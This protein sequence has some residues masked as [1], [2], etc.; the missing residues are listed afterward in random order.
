MN[1]RLTAGILLIVGGICT[2]AYFEYSFRP[3]EVDVPVALS[4]GHTT[5]EFIAQYD[6]RYRIGVGFGEPEK[7][8]Y[9]KSDCITD[10]GF[11]PG[12]CSSIPF[13]VKAAWRLSSG[14]QTIKQ[15]L[16]PS[17]MS[18]G[19]GPFFASFGVFQAEGARRYKLE[20]E[21]LTDGS[22]LAPARPRLQV[23]VREPEFGKTIGPG[24]RVLK[25]K[26]IVRA[27]YA[28]SILIGVVMILSWI[29]RRNA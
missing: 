12:D 17:T 11:P 27:C 28:I 4:V 23:H 22:A 20:V 1:W 2:L 21:F 26:T 29:D 15:G 16:A 9:N 13:P 14:G 5:V 18:R 19:S 8:A 10:P 24:L 7:I 3:G 6:A 25:S